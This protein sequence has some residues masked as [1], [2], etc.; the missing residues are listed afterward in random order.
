ME[1]YSM[2]L[3][4]RVLAAC[5]AGKDTR[6]V[7]KQFG[8]SPDW[9]RRLK[10]RRRESGEIAARKQGRRKGGPVQ[11]KRLI[12]L[13]RLVRLAP[14]ATLAQLVHPSDRPKRRREAHSSR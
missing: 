13:R 3:R 2:D 10:Q 7:A 14:D 8:V 12:A 1:A 4:R 11:R 5:D 6:E 9:V